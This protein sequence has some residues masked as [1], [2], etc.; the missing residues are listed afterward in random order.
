MT[1]REL[2]AGYWAAKLEEEGYSKPWMQ[3]RIQSLKRSEPVQQ[4]EACGECGNFLED[5]AYCSECD[6]FAAP[7]SLQG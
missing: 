3:E 7:P 1:P 2:E 5:R 6:A 4:V